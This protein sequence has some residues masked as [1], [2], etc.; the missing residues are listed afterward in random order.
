MRCAPKNWQHLTPQKL[1]PKILHGNLFSKLARFRRF[2]WHLV[3]PKTSMGTP[4][5]KLLQYN[6][7]K[8]LQKIIWRNKTTR[9]A[10]KVNFT[11]MRRSCFQK[12]MTYLVLFCI[13]IKNILFSY[14]FYCLIG[15]LGLRKF[16][17]QQIEQNMH[18][19]GA[20]PK[21]GNI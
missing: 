20:H 10:S 21:I 9:R 19:W 4:P 13:S 14:F 16:S 1:D 18:I 12:I 11:H 17:Q 15:S 5:L 6:F 2:C 8:W 7:A 3:A